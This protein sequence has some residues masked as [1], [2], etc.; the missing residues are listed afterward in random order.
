MPMHAECDIILPFFSFHVSIYLS[1]SVSTWPVLYQ[2][3]RTCL[4]FLIFS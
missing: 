3:E 1:V 4:I 2:K